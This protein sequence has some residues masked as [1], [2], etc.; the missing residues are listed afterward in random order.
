MRMKAWIAEKQ[1]MSAT[2]PVHPSPLVEQED[3]HPDSLLPS[4]ESGNISQ[5]PSRRISQFSDVA[6]RNAEDRRHT[7]FDQASEASETGD[8]SRR[9]TVEFVSSETR[10]RESMA[11]IS[12]SEHEIE[13]PRFSRASFFV[14]RS[15]WEQNRDTAIAKKRRF[16]LFQG[17]E[18]EILTETSRR[19]R[20]KSSKDGWWMK[21]VGLV[22]LLGLILMS[23][24]LHKRPRHRHPGSSPSFQN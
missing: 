21:K 22:R 8:L 17:Q 6:S 2:T 20:V 3:V 19:S 9:N 1:H 18:P 4:D 16:T 5:V 11:R 24:S 14:P 13:R 10:S 23:G 15:S 7:S 12:E